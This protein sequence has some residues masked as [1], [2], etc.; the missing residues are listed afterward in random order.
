MPVG[1]YDLA[2]GKFSRGGAPGRGAD[3]SKVHGKDLYL[4]NGEVQSTGYPLY[5]RQQDQHFITTARFPARGG[6]SGSW[7]SRWAFWARERTTRAILG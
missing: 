5:W 2:S 1:K 4:V 6:R 7:P 3:R